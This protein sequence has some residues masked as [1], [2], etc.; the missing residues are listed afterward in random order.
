MTGA[1]AMGTNKITGL[2]DPTNAQDATTKTYVDGI[3]G[4]A[5]AAAASA[6]AAATSASNAA[7]SETNAA[8]SASNAATSE[9]N[10][11]NSYDAFDD[12]FLG[13]KSSEPALD[14]DGDALLTGALFF[15]T[16]AAQMKVWNGSSWSQ[17]AF[18]INTLKILNRAGSLISVAIVDS[19]LPVLNRSGSTINVPVTT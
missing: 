13:A 18:V 15:D 12:R 19:L 11:A 2:G 10:A 5:T 6:A 7:T 8:T 14:N 9:T 4:S 16:T 3:L 17:A 1:I